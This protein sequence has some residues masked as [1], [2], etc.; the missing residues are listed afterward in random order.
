[1][2]N[3]PDFKQQ[4]ISF[5]AHLRHPK[6]NPPLEGIED[7]R[8]SIYRDLFINSLSS[9]VAGTYPVIHSLYTDDD[10]EALIRAFYYPEHNRTPHFP[11]IP[12]EFLS[13]IQNHLALPNNKPFLAE[14][15]LYEWLELHLDKH[16]HEEQFEAG[17][18]ST[19]IPV[20][21]TVSAL[22]AFN[23]PVHQISPTHQPTEPSDQPTFLL[24]WRDQEHQ[25]QFTELNPFSALLFERLQGNSSQTGLEL[26]TQ[27]SSEVQAPDGDAFI[28]HGLNNIKHWH[29]QG[30]ISHYR[31]TT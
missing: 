5:A 15:A 19:Q 1:M 18:P 29:E 31:S 26:L 10:W 20:I 7:R 11:E 24:L 6:D 13:F 21:N 8:L 2:P 25:V 27:L 16:Q 12:R 28:H 23:H 3:K 22:N 30:I 9:L 17:D 4:Q 14:L